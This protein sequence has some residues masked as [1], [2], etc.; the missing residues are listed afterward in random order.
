LQNTGYTQWFGLQD[1]ELLRAATLTLVGTRP[2][3]WQTGDV[4][5]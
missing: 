1:S 5:P 2:E 4:C 3:R